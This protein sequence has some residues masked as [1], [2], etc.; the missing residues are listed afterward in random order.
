MDGHCEEVLPGCP[1]LSDYH[2]GPR[3]GQRGA[4]QPGPVQ[5]HLVLPT[6]RL[7]ESGIPPPLLRTQ[8][9]EVFFPKEKAARFRATR[10]CK[11]IMFFKNI[12]TAVKTPPLLYFP[13]G[14][15]WVG[16]E[17]HRPNQGSRCFQ[18]ICPSSPTVSCPLCLGKRH[19]A[20]IPLTV[21]LLCALKWSGNLYWTQSLCRQGRHV[22]RASFAS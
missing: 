7:P 17:S 3:A 15:G 1:Q 2:G 4:R 5:A 21:E 19:V 18:S 14:W 8:P 22:S 9:A 12:R 10:F 13:G 11:F 16:G 20:V 6:P